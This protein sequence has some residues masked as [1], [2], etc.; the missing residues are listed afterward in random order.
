[1]RELKEEKKIKIN[2][3]RHLVS[4]VKIEL[5]EKSG[6]NVRKEKKICA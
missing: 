6:L 2:S 3:R 4:A 5:I 1:V